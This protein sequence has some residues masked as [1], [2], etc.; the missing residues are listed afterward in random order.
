MILDC[1]LNQ[2]YRDLDASL[3]GSPRWRWFWRSLAWLQQ[4]PVAATWL[5]LS[6]AVLFMAAIAVPAIND[7]VRRWQELGQ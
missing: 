7:G 1:R 6:V 5:Y 4:H 2:T 3:C